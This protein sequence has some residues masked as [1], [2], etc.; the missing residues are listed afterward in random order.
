MRTFASEVP[1]KPTEVSEALARTTTL[2]K[3]YKPVTPGLRH[4]RRPLNPHI[5]EGRPLRL[6]TVP[7]RKK[8]G[9]NSY[10]RITVRHRGGGHRRRIRIVDFMRM[11]PGPHDVVRIEYDPNRSAHIALIKNR[12]PTVDGLKQWSYILACEGLR[13]GNVVESFRQG[14]PDGFVPGFVDSR[15][16]RGNNVSTIEEGEEAKK[17]MSAGSESLALGL[18]RAKTI[19]PG[20]VLPLRLIP[21]GTVI[22]SIALK[23]EGRGILVRSAGSWGQVI[24]HEDSGK[25]THVRLQSGEVRKV[26]QDCAATI[27]KVSNPLWKNRSLGKAG[28][29]RWLGIRPTV[30]GVAMNAND[31]PHGGGRGKSKSNKHPRSPW[32]WLTKGK[33]TRKP[34]PKGPK[35]SNKMVIRE[36]PRGK[37]KRRQVATPN[38]PKFSTA[39]LT[40]ADKHGNQEVKILAIDVLSQLIPLYPTLHR[41]SHGSLLA[42]C[43]RKLNGSAPQSSNAQTLASA[44]R[45]Y[46]VLP[47][48]GGKVGAAN[49]WRSS[50]DDT[51]KFGWE[52]LAGLR[53]TFTADDRLA[54]LQS[55]QDA[56]GDPLVIVPLNV[57]RLRCTA[58]ALHELLRFANSRPVQVPLGQLVHFAMA[59]LRSTAEGQRP[60]HIDATTRAME[61]SVVPE[62]WAVACG[63]L[64]SLATST[65]HYLTPYVARFLTVIVFHLE[66]P[67]ASSH[68]LPF[69]RALTTLL[70]HTLP[71][72]HPILPTRLTKALLQSLT[73]LL[74]SQTAVQNAAADATSS[75]KGKRAK[76]RARGYEGDEVFNIA[77]NVMC[78]TAAEG[79]V[80]LAALDALRLVLGNPLLA[81]AAH[82]VAARLLLSIHISLPLVTPAQMSPDSCLYTHVVR[83]VHTLCLE[84][85]AGTSSV[86]SKSL[87][88]V[89]Q[90]L[91]SDEDHDVQQ[92]LDLLLHPR[93]PP[94]V[95]SLPHIDSISLFR[96]EEGDEERDIRETLGLG[97]T[98]CAEPAKEVDVQGPSGDVHMLEEP[99]S[100]PTL[101][102]P[103]FV[104]S[105]VPVPIASSW[106][107]PASAAPP[108]TAQ[109]DPPTSVPGVSS[110]QPHIPPPS[111]PSPSEPA[112]SAFPQ[113]PKE[114]PR[115]LA[116]K[117]Y[118]NLLP[119]EDDEDEEMPSIDM[120]SD[121]E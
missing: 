49:L 30:R 24:A 51:L 100:V 112:P 45:L 42:F 50:V 22:H 102:K 55:R 65:R 6:L 87:G 48:T 66:Q 54:A 104:P 120:G 10:G 119:V 33:R 85:A 83:V 8:G 13:A 12:D 53:T 14:I 71:L 78:P 82:S 92:R 81:P 90:E 88:M 56:A 59:L 41:A 98:G 15:K 7:L 52:A 28:R 31:H 9:R 27:G 89:I 70:K 47:V 35:N 29:A 37:E 97:V 76:K 103:A 26:L 21:N 110:T 62:I 1:S 63:L 75:G 19:R 106:A 118:S 4:L 67:L 38:V 108:A 68:R 44:A 43:L 40:L 94:L 101:N 69:I 80:V 115:P 105:A 18:L 57:D 95:R 74:P 25:Y 16:N 5:W 117:T 113:P 36:R 3:T 121:S 60:G 39:L 61:E 114:T 86:L 17:K 116:P 23:P 79:A 34:G 91:G 99:A 58:A 109:A 64:E 72:H 84:L 77:Q 32:G 73:A 20:N 2:Y 93:V 107:R 111:R 96:A 11:E 46:A